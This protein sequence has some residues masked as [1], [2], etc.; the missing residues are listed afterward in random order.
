MKYLV[1]LVVIFFIILLLT[2]TIKNTNEN[3]VIY[4]Q[5]PFGNY[6]TGSNSEL[7][8]ISFYERPRYKKPYMSPVCHNVNYP[9]PHCKNLDY[10]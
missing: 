6:K 5:L 9:V 8:V 1:R 2:Y 3:W 10:L 7:E 4:S